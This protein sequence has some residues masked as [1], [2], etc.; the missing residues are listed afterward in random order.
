MK[1]RKALFV[2]LV[3]ALFLVVSISACSDRV[4]T[5]DSVNNI[6]SDEEIDSIENLTGVFD[7]TGDSTDAR[8]EELN[9][10]YVENNK[11]EASD[12]TYVLPPEA[13]FYS[14]IETRLYA[15]INSGGLLLN[16]K[17]ERPVELDV[18]KYHLPG[19]YPEI[20]VNAIVFEEDVGAVNGK[21]ITTLVV[22]IM[23]EWLKHEG[24]EPFGT[25]M[26]PI[27]YVCMETIDDE[28]NHEVIN[29]GN[30]M[31]NPFTGTIE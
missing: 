22:K 7:N 13:E 5:P 4:E 9:K 14:F 27:S 15:E 19:N 24:F 2:V 12:T 21:A 1:T 10:S 25:L 23:L 6:G 31:Y 28:G 29:W 20:H 18:R 17:L 26:M 8:Q 11:D 30:S 3:L 16:T